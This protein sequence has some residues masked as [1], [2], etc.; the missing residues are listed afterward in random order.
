MISDKYRVRQHC[1]Y[2]RRSLGLAL[3]DFFYLLEDHPERWGISTAANGRL[4][5]AIRLTF[6]VNIPSPPQIALEGPMGGPMADG[7]GVSARAN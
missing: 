4:G 7:W 3:D 6:N 1:A 2:A 5:A